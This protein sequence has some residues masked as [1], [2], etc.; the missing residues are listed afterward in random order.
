[1]GQS[2]EVHG[3]MRE[4]EN[5]MDTYDFKRM[6]RKELDRMVLLEILKRLVKIDDYGVEI[7]Q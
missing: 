3:L 2:I 7:K 1:M 6:G 4:Y 5:R